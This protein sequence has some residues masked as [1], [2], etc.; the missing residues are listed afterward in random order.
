MPA[1]TLSPE[2]RQRAKAMWLSDQWTISAI[3]KEFGLESRDL[4]WL[5][6]VR[7]ERKTPTT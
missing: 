1:N 7:P 6:Y 3:A 4:G 5:L 2:Q